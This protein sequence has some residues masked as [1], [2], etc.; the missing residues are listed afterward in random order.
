MLNMI[1]FE[2]DKEGYLKD[3]MKKNQLRIK[4]VIYPKTEAEN[5]KYKNYIIG[6]EYIESGIGNKIV[7]LKEEIMDKTKGAKK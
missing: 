2:K 7:M 1:K 3:C 5:D 6:N 4:K